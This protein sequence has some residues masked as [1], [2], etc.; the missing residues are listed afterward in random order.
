MADL[1]TVQDYKDAEGLTGAK[2]DD[3]LNILVPQI[4]ELVKKYCGTS[5]VDFFSSDK[6]ETFN[7]TEDTSV[8]IVS[9]SPLVSVTSVKERGSPTES[10]TTLTVNEDYYVDTTFDAVR[11]IVGNGTKNYQKGFGA[12]QIAYRSGYSAVPSDLKLAVMDLVTY[13]L[14]DEHTSRRSLQG[15]TL[16]N[17]GTSSVRNNTDFPDHI[18]RVLDLYRVI[19]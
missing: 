6:T 17:Q 14:R 13:Y 5:F 4:S 15:A 9:E 7:V 3:R 19:V 2:D 11:R 18:K 8:I 1:V 16:D 12:V 10:Y